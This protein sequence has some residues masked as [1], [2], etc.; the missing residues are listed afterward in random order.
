MKF[1]ILKKSVNLKFRDKKCHIIIISHFPRQYRFQ[2]HL[3]LFSPLNLT[4][5]VVVSF[6]DEKVAKG[7]TVPI[8]HLILQLE[9][10]L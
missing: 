2:S 3:N 9:H 10:R 7:K 1:K 6:Q 8:S 5:S 4:F